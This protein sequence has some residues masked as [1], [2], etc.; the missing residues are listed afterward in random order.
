MCVACRKLRPRTELFRLVQR[1]SG[2]RILADPEYRLSGKGIYL[3][4]SQECL[5]RLRKERRLRRL[6]LGRFAEGTLEQLA[7]RLPG[8]EKNQGTDPLPGR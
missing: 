3:C 5:G 7:E 4:R 2:D 1:K 8:S 6:F